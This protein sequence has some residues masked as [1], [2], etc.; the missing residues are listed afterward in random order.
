MSYNIKMNNKTYEMKNK[1]IEVAKRIKEFTTIQQK[2]E[3][4]PDKVEEIIN[5]Q[6]D[7]ACEILGMEAVNEILGAD[8]TEIDVDEL[9]DL[10][11]VIL[12]GYESKALKKRRERDEKK[13][14]DLVNSKNINKLMDVADKVSNISNQR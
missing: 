3:Q 4:E 10:S 11:F 14:A 5:D 7:F 13:I 12:E 8:I 1:T 2:L 6:Y 9:L